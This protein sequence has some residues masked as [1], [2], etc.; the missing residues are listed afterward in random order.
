MIINYTPFNTH[1]NVK[2]QPVCMNFKFVC[3]ILEIRR[4]MYST[5]SF[6]VNTNLLIWDL[7]IIYLPTDWLTTEVQSFF[8][9][10]DLSFHILYCILYI[11]ENQYRICSHTILVCGIFCVPSVILISLASN[12]ITIATFCTSLPYHHILTTLCAKNKLLWFR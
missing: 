7:N 6:L 4:E 8:I 1:F 3:V 2:S 10:Y 12:K 9:D 5:S 11:V